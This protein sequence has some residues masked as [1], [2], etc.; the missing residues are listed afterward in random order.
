MKQCPTLIL[1]PDMAA[2]YCYQFI[3]LDGYLQ[4]HTTNLHQIFVRV[5]HGHGSV[6]LHVRW[7]RDTRLVSTTALLCYDV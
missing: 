3:C 1:G 4:K 5:T 2:E 7:H 6:H